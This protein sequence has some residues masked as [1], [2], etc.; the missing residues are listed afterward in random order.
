M[1]D[2]FLSAQLEQG[3]LLGPF[4]PQD[5]PAVITS[6]LA[7]IPKKTFGKWRVIVDLSRPKGHSVNDSLLRQHTHLAYAS[8]EDAAH[9]MHHLG[10][11]SL[12]A[13]LDIKDAYR[14]VPIH[15]YD[16]RFLGIQW[17][18]N[19][20]VDCQLPFGLASAPAIF[21]ALSQA[22][23]W[24]LR[25]RGVGSVLHYIDDFLLLGPP[26]SP[27]CAHDLALTLST[28]AELGIPL[29]QEKIEGPVTALSF[30]GIQ[31]SS[32][33]M[34]LTLPADKL[35]QLRSLLREFI[36]TPRVYNH[37]RFESLVGHLVHATKVCPLAKAYLNALFDFK[38][39]LK[40]GQPRRLNKEALTEIAWWDTLLSQWQGTSVQQFLLLRHPDHHLFTDAS[41]SWGC[42]AWCGTQWLQVPWSSTS[43]LTSIALKELFPVVLA[44]AVWGHSWHGCLI[45]CHSDN[46]AVVCQVNKLHAR[47]PLAAHMLRC[48]AM[49]QA[50]YDCRIRAVHIPGR[51]NYGADDLSRNRSKSFLTAHPTV[52]PQPTQVPQM[53]LSRLTQVDP[54][55]TSQ[56]WRESS[57][58][59]WRL[60]WHHP[61]GKCMPLLGSDTHAL[62]QSFTSPPCPS[63]TKRPSCLLPF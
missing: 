41:G 37:S 25:Q 23:E 22:L 44:A 50:L 62:L 9:I 61:P 55:W 38:A 40:P 5:C 15:P 7:V 47:D 54:S 28:C 45:I 43:P 51:A 20:Y 36:Q 52:S 35:Q 6:S 4:P 49:F 19:V 59:L 8:V 11:G 57:N 34:S 1:V 56:A 31:L 60:A 27:R 48:L 58:D 29:A 14:M 18:N 3:Y 46:M 63:Q 39:C 33:H 32:Q 30:L 10:Q 24:I 16:R 21:C 17:K 26:N 42:G 53:A 12:L 13:K 2:S